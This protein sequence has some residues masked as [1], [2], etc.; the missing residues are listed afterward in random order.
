MLNNY[1]K[2]VPN[3]NQKLLNKRGRASNGSAKPPPAKRANVRGEKARQEATPSPT[4]DWD[5]THADTVEKYKDVESWEDLVESVDTVER[6]NEG[7]TV[8]MTM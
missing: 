6:A 8:F 4:P 1:W 3:T 2:R 5:K 7:L